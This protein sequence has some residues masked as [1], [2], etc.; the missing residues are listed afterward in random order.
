MR[1]TRH[2]KP[3]GCSS[4]NFRVRIENILIFFL[5]ES[6]VL[7]HKLRALL[8]PHLMAYQSG[9]L[10]RKCPVLKSVVPT[11]MSPLRGGQ[12]QSGCKTHCETRVV[13]Y[14]GLGLSGSVWDFQDQSDPDC[15]RCPGQNGTVMYRSTRCLSESP[16]LR[17]TQQAQLLVIF[18]SQ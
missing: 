15:H 18:S 7:F 1:L 2:Q 16:S 5:H 9:G 12:G 8:F 11:F 10:Q 17:Q 6:N 4:L 13:P 3:A 14:R